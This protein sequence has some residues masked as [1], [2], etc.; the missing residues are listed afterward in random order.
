MTEVDQTLKSKV[1]E[2]VQKVKKTRKVVKYLAMEPVVDADVKGVI[3]PLEGWDRSSRMA[4][5]DKFLEKNTKAILDR[6]DTDEVQIAVFPPPII[7]TVY[8]ETRMGVR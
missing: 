8:R 7:K 1:D 3:K 5:L 2:H 6:Y 4:D